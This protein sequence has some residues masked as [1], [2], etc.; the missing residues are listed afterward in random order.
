MSSEADGAAS[1]A[2]SLRV[3]CSSEVATAPVEDSGGEEDDHL[4]LSDSSGGGDD[5]VGGLGLG[6]LGLASASLKLIASGDLAVSARPIPIPTP[7]KR[8]SFVKNDHGKWLKML[9]RCSHNSRLPFKNCREVKY[10]HCMSRNRRG[11]GRGNSQLKTPFFFLAEFMRIA[12]LNFSFVCLI[13]RLPP[14]KE[15]LSLQHSRQV[16]D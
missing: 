15:S 10:V 11:T 6:S 12:G 7:P 9:F 16:E 14:E 1:T 13:P 8:S 2:A 3:I 4:L 5:E